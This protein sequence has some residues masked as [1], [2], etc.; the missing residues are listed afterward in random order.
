MLVQAALNGPS[1]KGITRRWPLIR[2]AL[3][4]DIDTRVGLEDVSR[5]PDG[6]I[7][8]GNAALVEAVAELAN[9]RM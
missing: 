4:R 5:M 2:D 3:E 9:G 8:A 7:V 6:E 1:T